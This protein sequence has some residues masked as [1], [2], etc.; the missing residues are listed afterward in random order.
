MAPQIK[1]GKETVASMEERLLGPKKGSVFPGKRKLV[2]RLAFESIARAVSHVFSSP[3][4]TS[5]SKMI[6]DDKIFP[7]PDGLR[8]EHHKNQQS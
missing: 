4:S 2:K 7:D 1:P 5:R 3:T 6:Q 8:P